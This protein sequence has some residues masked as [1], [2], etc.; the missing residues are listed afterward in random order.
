MALRPEDRPAS[1]GELQ[2][3]VRS[4]QNGGRERPALFGV[5]GLFRGRKA[6]S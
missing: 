3:Q 4:F 2:A 6:K 1:V 5:E